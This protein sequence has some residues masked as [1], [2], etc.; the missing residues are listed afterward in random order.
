MMAPLES[1][2]QSVG[3]TTAITLEDDAESSL[4]V[5][6][7]LSFLIGSQF[8][9]SLHQSHVY[10]FNRARPGP[11]HLIVIVTRHQRNPVASRFV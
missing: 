6:L 1:F 11:G 8:T 10:N 5:Y 9:I 2:A 4:K 7:L 3:S